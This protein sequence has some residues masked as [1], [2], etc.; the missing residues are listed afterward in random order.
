MAGHFS[1]LVD[2]TSTGILDACLKPEN[3]NAIQ[4]HGIMQGYLKTM[5]YSLKVGLT[6]TFENAVQKDVRIEHDNKRLS[7]AISEMKVHKVHFQSVLKAIGQLHDDLVG[8]D[9]KPELRDL[10]FSKNEIIDR[11]PAI[12]NQAFNSN[13]EFAR[14]EN[15]MLEI[16]NYFEKTSSKVTE[17]VNVQLWNKIFNQ[18]RSG[19]LFEASPSRDEDMKTSNQQRDSR[20]ANQTRYEAPRQKVSGLDNFTDNQM[21]PNFQTDRLKFLDRLDGD[22]HCVV[23]F[24]EVKDERNMNDGD[25]CL[26]A[27][28]NQHNLSEN[29]N[30]PSRSNTELNSLS[31]Q[32]HLSSNQSDRSD[33]RRTRLPAR[34]HRTRT[35]HTEIWIPRTLKGMNKSQRGSRFASHP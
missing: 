7:Q 6:R 13:E 30:L 11:N 10:M 19:R 1:E 5:A 9:M 33:R 20:M 26:E 24:E 15:E 29:S 17:F 34:S 12:S 35:E 32:P 18:P 21:V 23:D 28:N 25:S 4:H 3:D 31:M 22:D 16:S 14:L 8:S 2:E 27:D